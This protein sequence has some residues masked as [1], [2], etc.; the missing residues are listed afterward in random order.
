MITVWQTGRR[1]SR[2]GDIM[3]AR[4]EKC[5][6]GGMGHTARWRHDFCRLRKWLVTDLPQA[7]PI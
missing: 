2:H 6:E 4:E 1:V 5:N 7:G 3:S